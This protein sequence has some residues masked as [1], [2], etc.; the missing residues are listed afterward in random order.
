MKSHITDLKALEAGLKRF[1]RENIKEERENRIRK[2]KGDLRTPT[3]FFLY[4]I[5]FD[6]G[7]RHL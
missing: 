4:Y 5:N 7:N 6:D 2:S 3:N 1:Q